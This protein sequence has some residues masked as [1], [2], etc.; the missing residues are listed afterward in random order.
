MVWLGR[1]NI[2]FKVER[3]CG[4]CLVANVAYLQC[5]SD[6]KHVEPVLMMAAALLSKAAECMYTA[7]VA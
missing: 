4:H 2:D 3:Y 5:A 7:V 6:Q 1:N